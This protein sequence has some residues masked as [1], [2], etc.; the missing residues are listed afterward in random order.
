MG[1]PFTFVHAADLHLD[2]PFKGLTKVPAAVRERLRESTFVALG[3][4]SEVVEKEKADFVVLAGDLFDVADRSL[5]AQLRLQRALGT[6]TAHGARVFIVHGNHDPESG[7]QARLDWPEGVF[8]FGSATVGCIPAYSRKGDLVAH[9]YGISYPTPSVTDNLALR[10]K[11]REGA[12]FHLA[13]LHANV[14]GDPSHDNYAPCKLEEL[15]TSGFDYWA[16]GH[17]HDRRVLSEYPHVVYAGNMQGRSIRETGGKGAYVVSV[18]EA[19]SIEMKFKDLADVL[20]REIPV[21]IEG[22]ESE[23]QLKNRLLSAL[24]AVRGEAGG[25]PSVVRIKLEGRGMLHE[26]LLQPNVAEEWIEELREWLGEPEETDAWIWPESIAVRTGGIVRLESVAEEEG[27]VG[28]LIRGGLAATEHS[29]ASREL[30]DE[31]METLRKQPKIRE[32]LESRSHEE[33]SQWIVQALELSVSL[34]RE[35]RDGADNRS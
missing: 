12:P 16:L 33:R 1:V 24:E 14:D 35:D 30:L 7:R 11:K 23:Q 21:S 17:V 34:L 3:K 27:F 29:D 26:R 32:W 18:N 25:R 6:M 2:S 15:I 31:A 13:L 9:V 8:A 22:M 28:E 20:W 4:L 19:G 10:F 5:R